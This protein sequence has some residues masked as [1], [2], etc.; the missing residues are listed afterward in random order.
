MS[1]AIEYE[2]QFIRSDKGITPCWLAGDNN[3]YEPSYRGKAERRARSWS[4][5]YNLLATTEEAILEAIQ[6]SLGGYGEHW[7]RGGKWVDDAG[8]I[9]WVKSGCKSAATVEE[10]L[11]NNRGCG[12]SVH[13][14]ASVWY[15]DGE[16]YSDGTLKRRNKSDISTYVHTSEEFDAWIETAETLREECKAKG[17]SFYPIIDFGTEKLVHRVS[18]PKDDQKVV[19]RCGSG[20]RISYLIEVSD[21]HSTWGKVQDALVIT[22]TAAAELQ[23]TSPFEWVRKARVVDAKIKECP[24]NV[25]LQFVDGVRAGK[26][27]SQ[28]SR[29]NLWMTDHVDSA[30]RYKDVSAARAALKRIQPRFTKSGTLQVVVIGGGEEDKA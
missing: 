3:V 24:H 26:Y 9:R 8:L 6:P 12:V 21:S 27:V 19:L 10:I 1:Y 22:G 16:C 15:T 17:W 5:F 25:A 13:C 2:R 23:R 11:A 29:T 18:T 7:I 4:V 28:V 30:K 20:S 14:F